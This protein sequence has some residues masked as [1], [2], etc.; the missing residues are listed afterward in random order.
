MGF[1]VSISPTFPGFII[2]SRWFTGNVKIIELEIECNVFEIQPGAFIAEAFET[3]SKLT[4]RRIGARVLRTGIFNGLYSLKELTIMLTEVLVIQNNLLAP[5]QSTLTTLTMTQQPL[6]SRIHL[7]NGLTGNAPMVALNIVNFNGNN[8]RDTITKQTFIG[9]V[10]VETLILSDAGIEILGD[11]VFDSIANTIQTIDLRNNKLIHLPTLLFDNILPNM[12]LRLFMNGNN[13]LCDCDL[14]SFQL[15]IIHFPDVFVDETLC[16]NPTF[17]RDEP[18]NTTQF[19]TQSVTQT[20][21]LPTATTEAILTTEIIDNPAYVE[22][23]CY[24]YSGNSDME[25]LINITPRNTIFHVISTANNG[26]VILV[27]ENVSTN[28]IL[29]WFGG[30]SNSINYQNYANNFNCTHSISRNII[31]K[32]LQINSTY[33]F[34]IMNKYQT[35]LSPFNC[36]PHFINGQNFSN[37]NNIP[38]WR[39]SQETKILSIIFYI[40]SSLLWIC[41]GTLIGY[42][43][44]KNNPHW[45]IAPM[46]GENK[47]IVIV[48]N[49]VKNLGKNDTCI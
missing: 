16:V 11:Q 3:I 22:K 36:I 41:I 8:F 5:V 31:I 10:A 49:T 30:T 23:N 46:G 13:W 35:T 27:I 48:K 42:F 2:T 14:L 44:I 43:I 17:Y 18:I 21:Q 9:L 15:A 12:N 26:D 47:D 19:C 33:I 24:D 40:V 32:N 4:L 20:T 6:T 1:N 45:I 38:I 28:F 39:L 34:C 7:P 29:L 37:D 25:H